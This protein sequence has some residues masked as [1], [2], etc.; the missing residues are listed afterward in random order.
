MEGVDREKELLILEEEIQKHQKKIMRLPNN[1]VCVVNTNDNFIKNFVY[2]SDELNHDT[3]LVE[4]MIDFIKPGGVYVEVGANYGDFVFQVSRKIGDQGRV[5][6]F[7]PNRDVYFNLKMGAIIN[8]L[9]NVVTENAAVYDVESEKYFVET[10]NSDDFGTLGSYISNSEIANN[11]QSTVLMKTITLDNYFNNKTKAIN[12]LRLDVEGSEF[13]ILRGSQKLVSLSPDLVIYIEWQKNLLA[14]YESMQELE[15]NLDKLISLGFIFIATA[16][17]R[18]DCDDSFYKITKTSI[19]MSNYIEFIALRE[20]TLENYLREHNSIGVQSECSSLIN[21]Y[22]FQSANSGDIDSVNRFLEK[23]ADVNYFGGPGATSLYMS[24]QDGNTDLVLFLLVKGAN[25][26]IKA[27]NGLSPL[28]I[29]IQNRH[30]KIAEALLEHRANTESAIPSGSTPLYY[31]AYYG[32]LDAVKLLLKYGANKNVVLNGINVMQAAQNNGHNE[33]VQLLQ[34]SNVYS[35]MLFSSSQVG[36]FASVEELISQGV[37]INYL[38]PQLQATS[39]YI[40]SQNGHTKVVELLL[41]NKANPEICWGS[42]SPLFMAVQNKHK[43]IARLLLKYGA[44]PE[45]GKSSGVTALYIAVTQEDDESVELLLE[46]K[47]NTEI[48]IGEYTPLSL[49]AYNGLTQIVR[50]LVQYGANREVT[51][52]GFNLLYI[53]AKRG[54]I[55]IAEILLERGFNINEGQ[56]NG[57]T[58][59]DIAAEHNKTEMVKFLLAK[60]ANVGVSQKQIFK[61]LL[62]DAQV[63]SNLLEHKYENTVLEVI[64][65]QQN[66][67][68]IAEDMFTKLIKKMTII[69]EC[70]QG[71]EAEATNFVD[72]CGLDGPYF[73]EHYHEQ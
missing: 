14:R 29:A 26:E 11:S 13:R 61:L 54:F 44:S 55:E 48:K 4:L 51:I 19:L 67:S 15:E 34:N 50:L 33:V 37:D 52:D 49:A 16:R 2:S 24:A 62:A 36:A 45:T 71:N 69:K 70:L 3:Y 72:V 66:S 46:Y 28:Y 41:K 73:M 5:Y 21:E 64:L 12:L 25:P 23:G 20:A 6:A 57:R 38:H 65:K 8:N 10:D 9:H 40:A 59:L 47:A 58:A 42:M 56:V 31:A 53:A 22:L 30:I 35:E 63:E 60:G 7:E 1:L 32:Y 39:L 17:F 68:A 27:I 18:R 43:D